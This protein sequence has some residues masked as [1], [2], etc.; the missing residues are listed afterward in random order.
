LKPAG[1]EEGLVRITKKNRDTAKT[2]KKQIINK[3]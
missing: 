2:N 1:N 3:G